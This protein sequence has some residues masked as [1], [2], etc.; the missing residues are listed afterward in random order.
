RFETESPLSHGS[1]LHQ[2]N[3]ISLPTRV[4]RFSGIASRPRQPIPFKVLAQ[5]ILS[6]SI[7]IPR[8]PTSSPVPVRLPHRIRTD[9][10]AV[11]KRRPALAVSGCLA[12]SGRYFANIRKRYIGC[13]SGHFATFGK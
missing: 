1:E 4:T 3:R 5:P 10:A 13:G 12:R 11:L 6:P 2:G 7:K 8:P 9:R